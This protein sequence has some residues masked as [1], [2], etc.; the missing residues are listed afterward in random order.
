M[1]EILFILAVSS[2][3]LYSMVPD[4]KV[5]YT[6][7]DIMN[8]VETRILKIEDFNSISFGIR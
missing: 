5:N 3:S 4:F 6:V 2:S 1:K 7:Q 8:E